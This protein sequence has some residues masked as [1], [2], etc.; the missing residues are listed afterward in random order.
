MRFE[1]FGLEVTREGSTATVTLSGEFD[2][3]NVPAVEAG[4]PEVQPGGRLVVDLRGLG[5]MD[6]SGVRVLMTLD[7][8][9]RSEGWTLVVVCGP[10]PVRRMLDLCRLSERIQLVDN[11]ADAA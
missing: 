6:S 2:M 1:P 9:A 11:P 4:L 3:A 8:R 7:V 10:G 5:F